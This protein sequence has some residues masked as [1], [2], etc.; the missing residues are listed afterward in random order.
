ML[1]KKS[2][3]EKVSA[4]TLIGLIPNT[5]IKKLTQ[6]LSTDKWVK[7]LDSHS[8]FN[9]LLFSILSSDRL[10][11]RIM[12]D[13][14]KDPLFQLLSGELKEVNIAHTG[15]RDRL[16]NINVDFFKSIYEYLYQE[17]AKHYS[18]QTLSCYNIKRYDSTMIATFSHLLTG[19]KVGNTS[20]GKEQVKM[21]MEFKNDFLI[22]SNFYSDQKH[23]SE[24]TAL[25]EVITEF[26]T[27]EIVKNDTRKNIHVF[28]KGL[29]SRKTF[30]NFDNDN[31]KFVTRLNQEPR[32]KIISPNL[33]AK[34]SDEYYDTN[35]LEFIHDLNVQL[36]K[37]GHNDLTTHSFRLIEFYIK[38]KS[39]KTKKISFLTNIDDIS[40]NE[41]ADIYRHRWDIEVLFRFMKQEMNL[42]HF[43]CNNANAI[44]IMC[45][46]H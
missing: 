24:E 6:E 10:S 2:R 45:M 20:L 1:S 8:F 16:I 44:Q 33:I 9:L 40:H 27:D 23:L 22:R 37:N 38:D 19:I 39:K 26:S 14:F 41:I 35:E 43:V 3:S 34:T 28:D 25:K 15:I 21:T 36:Y 17:I 11:L 46:L 12:E 29:K 4:K 5:L 7:K 32:Y 42:S 30:E 18:N 13:N 31:I